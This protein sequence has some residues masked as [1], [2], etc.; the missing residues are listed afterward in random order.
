VRTSSFDSAIEDAVSGAVRIWLEAI[1]VFCRFM[2][3]VGRMFYK[4]KH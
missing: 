1:T 4:S 3:L 2:E